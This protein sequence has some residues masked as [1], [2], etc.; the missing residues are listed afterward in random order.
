HDLSVVKYFCDRI[1]VMYF[2]K[3]VELASSDEL[4]ANPLHPYT[5]SLLS[6]IPK[7]NPLTEKTRERIVYHPNE[8]HDYSVD[9]PM[10]KEIKKGHFIYCNEKEFDDYL[11]IL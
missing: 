8:V 5:R 7:P 11:K 10:L 3:V 6:A 9:K 1:A 4:F 2:G